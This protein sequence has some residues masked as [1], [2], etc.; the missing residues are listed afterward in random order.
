MILTSILL[1]AVVGGVIGAG[2]ALYWKKIHQWLKRV[3]EKLPQK[4]INTLKGVLSFVKKSVNTAY[5]IMKYYSYDKYTKQWNETIVTK[6]VDESEIPEHI[7]NRVN[8]NLSKEIETTDELQEI[9]LEI[10]S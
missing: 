3:L 4:I 7:R 8:A 5:N 9:L 6:E 10:K 2:I 1:T